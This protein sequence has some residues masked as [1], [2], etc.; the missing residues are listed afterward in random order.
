MAGTHCRP[1]PPSNLRWCSQAERSSAQG[2][3]QEYSAGASAST[4]S[5]TG[6]EDAK[7][8]VI[9]TRRLASAR[10]HDTSIYFLS[11]LTA[12][13]GCMAPSVFPTAVFLKQK[14]RRGLVHFI[15][16]ATSTGTLSYFGNYCY[17]N[18]RGRSGDLS[19]KA[20]GE[21]VDDM[22]H[23]F[24]AVTFEVVQRSFHLDVGDVVGAGGTDDL[25]RL[26]NADFR[27]GGGVDQ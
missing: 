5:P 21:P 3:E 20:F 11:I 7:I 2:Y 15:G 18:N 1:R 22:L 17:S 4:T 16:R 8:W 25:L 14:F 9:H 23:R 6:I 27:V 12:T 10:R 19:G 26:P 24:G 13:H